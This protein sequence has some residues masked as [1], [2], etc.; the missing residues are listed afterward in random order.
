MNTRPA[1]GLNG[2]TSRRTVWSMASLDNACEEEDFVG[3]TSEHSPKK[4][5]QA[6]LP[7][8]NWTES[9]KCSIHKSVTGNKEPRHGQ[10]WRRYTE[11][12][13][14]ALE[15]KRVPEGVWMRCDGC[16]ATLICKQVDQNSKVCP[17]CN[18]HFPVTAVERINQLLDQDTFEDWFSDLQPADPL[19]F[20]DRRPYPE[21]VKAEQERTGLNEAALVGQGFIKGI[22][23]VFGITDSNF[24]MG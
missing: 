23:I 8:K 11:F 5:N 15:S 7:E 19:G 18:H 1:A 12:L 4:A 16:S 6:T 2:L 20:D 22:R 24:I 14:W 3:A 9:R 10:K 13:A 21:R 17:E